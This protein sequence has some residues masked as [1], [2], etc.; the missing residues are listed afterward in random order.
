[1]QMN[2]HYLIRMNINSIV[3]QSNEFSSYSE[4]VHIAIV[5]WK[6]YI[7]KQI[8]FF[9]KIKTYQESNS[10]KNIFKMDFDG[11]IILITG[12]FLAFL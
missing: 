2:A 9:L 3:F 4:F 12:K 6:N 8:S 10:R 5:L 11:K 7:Q 1:M